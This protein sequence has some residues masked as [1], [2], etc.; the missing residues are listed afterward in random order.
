[1]VKNSS[2]LKLDTPLA[3]GDFLLE[4]NRFDPKDYEIFVIT[5]LNKSNDVMYIKRVL[6]SKKKS[7]HSDKELYTIISY[8]CSQHNTAWLTYKLH[9]DHPYVLLYGKNT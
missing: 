9:D 3:P 7:W 5:R 2:Y 1:M 6:S 8:H 4:R